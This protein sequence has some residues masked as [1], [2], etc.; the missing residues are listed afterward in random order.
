MVT[1]NKGFSLLELIIIIAILGIT[2]AI[3]A[4]GL[5]T[6]ISN[7][8][9]SGSINEFVAA[10][11]FAKAESATRVNPVTICK[12]KKNKNDKCEDND[13][14]QLGWIVFSDLDGDAKI[15]NEDTVLLVHEPLDERITFG[16]T[17][18][19]EETITYQPTGTTTITATEVLIMCDDRGFAESAK[20]VLVTIT[21]RGSV[22]KASDTGQ[23]SCL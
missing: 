16:G 22:M 6:M 9:V 12:K 10:L 19:V 18:G 17:A 14:W 20:G 8:R 15:D 23:N 4:P 13:D 1:H 21:G 7:S 5:G 2:M 3:A 11:Q